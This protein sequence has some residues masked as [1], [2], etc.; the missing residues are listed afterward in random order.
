MFQQSVPALLEDATQ[1]YSG[2]GNKFGVLHALAALAP[3]VGAGQLGPFVR[4]LQL[5][6]SSDPSEDSLAAEEQRVLA[7]VCALG[8]DRC[9]DRH[10]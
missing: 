8:F 5:D 6:H 9:Q 4:A 3:L 7:R 10:T 1:Q 2:A